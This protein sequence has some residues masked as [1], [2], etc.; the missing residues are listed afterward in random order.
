[1]THAT[2]WGWRFSLGFAFI[3]SFLLFLGEPCSGS[4][5]PRVLFAKTWHKSSEASLTLQYSTFFLLPAFCKKG[6]LA[7]LMENT[8]ASV[9]SLAVYAFVARFK[10]LYN[11]SDPGRGKICVVSFLPI[12]YCILQEESSYLTHQTVFLSEDTLSR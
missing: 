6:K 12:R 10:L 2:R 11:L 8:K 4:H 5:Q 9:V 3:P 7:R 1:M